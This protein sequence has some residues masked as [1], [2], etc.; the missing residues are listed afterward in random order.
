MGKRGTPKWKKKYV[1]ME[2]KV[3]EPPGEMMR[4][5]KEQEAEHRGY[6]REMARLPRDKQVRHTE[7]KKIQK[8]KGAVWEMIK[9]SAEVTY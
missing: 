5:W 6:M 7:W 4:R 8:Q 2:I 1:P 9:G 3:D